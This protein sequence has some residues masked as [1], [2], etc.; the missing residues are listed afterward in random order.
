MTPA[1]HLKTEGH[2]SYADEAMD[3]HVRVLLLVMDAPL[4]GRMHRFPITR[5]AAPTVS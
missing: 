4:I 2:Q 3:A 1:R 5:Q